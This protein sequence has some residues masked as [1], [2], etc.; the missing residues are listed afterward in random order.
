MKKAYGQKFILK[1]ARLKLMIIPLYR[2]ASCFM[3]EE[4][5]KN[6]FNKLKKTSKIIK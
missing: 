4:K 6:I 2:P 5:T 1:K 3:G